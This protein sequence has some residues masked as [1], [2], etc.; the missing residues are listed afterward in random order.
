MLAPTIGGGA[1]GECTREAG[2]LGYNEVS[3]SIF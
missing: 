2:I 1:A 3:D